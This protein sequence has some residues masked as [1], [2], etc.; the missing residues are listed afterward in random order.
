MVAFP[1]NLAGNLVT[2]FI[3]SMFW[4]LLNFNI[5][6]RRGRFIAS[7]TELTEWKF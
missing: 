3:R 4:S 5:E 6:W 2:E 7:H 1:T